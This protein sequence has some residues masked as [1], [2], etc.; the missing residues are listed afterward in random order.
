MT[1]HF[2]TDLIRNALWTCFW[3]SAPLLLIG[4]TVGLIMNVI[5]VVTSLQDSSFSFVPKL[6]AF[7]AALIVCLPWMFSRLS[8]YTTALFGDFS[9]YTR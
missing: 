9:A 7:L 1:P 2:A 5:Q 6:A 4:F 8:A 3:V